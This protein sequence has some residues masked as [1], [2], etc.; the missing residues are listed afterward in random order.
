MAPEVVKAVRAVVPGS[1]YRR[2]AGSGHSVYWEQ[3]DA[4]NEALGTFL[5]RHAARG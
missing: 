4:L 3:P 1:E 5:G 2:F